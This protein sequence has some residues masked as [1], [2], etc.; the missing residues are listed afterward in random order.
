[1]ATEYWLPTRPYTL[2]DACNRM[3]AA[4]GSHRAAIASMNAN[5]NGHR[6][7]V[8]YSQYRKWAATYTWSGI[9]WLA[10]RCDFE[11]ALEAALRDYN[12]GDLGSEVIVKCETDEQVEICKAKG[13]VPF[14]GFEAR[15]QMVADFIGPL[16]PRV[17]EA[18][19]NGT[20]GILIE[21]SSVE[22]Y[23]QRVR[24]RRAR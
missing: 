17:N 9:R 22:E 7:R 23:D 3:A 16:A 8:D 10:S 24:E 13:M 20:T 4:T 6:V 18:V 2:I 5:Y 11:T 1:M 14:P 12:R 15:N 19:R 21:C